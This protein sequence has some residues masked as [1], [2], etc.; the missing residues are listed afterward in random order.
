M[1]VLPAYPVLHSPPA[2]ALLQQ[3]RNDAAGA[4]CSCTGEQQQQQQTWQ[5]PG[6]QEQQQQEKKEEQQQPQPGSSPASATPVP[7][8]SALPRLPSSGRP[9]AHRR[10]LLFGGVVRIVEP[11][12]DLHFAPGQVEE[13]MAA[14][15]AGALG[16]LCVSTDP[17]YC[18]AVSSA[19]LRVACLVLGYVCVGRVGGRESR[20]RC[21]QSCNRLVLCLCLRACLQEH[22]L[23]SRL[24]AY[25]TLSLP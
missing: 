23:A 25:P 15:R 5:Q 20:G 11:G 3:P 22:S 18:R 16:T 1:E 21:V 17:L 19:C 6:Q 10:R 9:G 13:G 7:L 4:H 14:L 24:F 8:T 12:V 2:A